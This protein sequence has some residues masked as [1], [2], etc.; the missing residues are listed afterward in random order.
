VDVA[1][2]GAADVNDGPRRR[3]L[4]LAILVYVVLVALVV[5]TVLLG[6]RLRSTS[7]RDDARDEVIAAARQR[8]V[9]LLSIDYRSAARD[10][11]RIIDDSTGQQQNIYRAQVKAFPAILQQTKSVSTGEVLAAGLVSFHGDKASVALAV[12]QSVSTTA[13]AGQ[14]NTARRMVLDLQRVH[15]RWLVS[16]QTFVGQGVVL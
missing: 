3:R 9:N 13:A 1:D 12:N 14:V 11:Q 4:P 15:G 10:L 5:V 16:K 8:A 2:P 7:N 6:L